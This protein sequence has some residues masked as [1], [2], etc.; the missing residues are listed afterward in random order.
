VSYGPWV[1]YATI[2]YHELLVVS[3]CAQIPIPISLS[4]SILKVLTSNENL[5]ALYTFSLGEWPR[6]PLL[7]ATFSPAQPRARRDA[8]LSQASTV[9][10]CAFCEQEG[11]LAAPSSSF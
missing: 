6:L 7:H 2:T 9:S 4:L 5:E 11:H 3:H 1:Q 8:L 10:S